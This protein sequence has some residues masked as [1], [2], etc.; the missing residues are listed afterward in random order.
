MRLTRREF[1]QL[2]GAAATALTLG[3]CFGGLAAN[4]GSAGAASASRP[5]RPNIILIV[6]DD[7]GFSDLGCYGSEISTPNIDKLAANGLRGTQF[8][9]TARCCPSRAALMTGLYPHRAGMGWMTVA[10]LGQPGYV[11]ELNEHCITIAQGLKPAGYRCYM[12]GKWHLCFDK[13]MQADSPKHNWPLQRGYD[14]YYG[15]LAGDGSHYKPLGLTRD[16]TR[17]DAP[18]EGYY[19]TDATADNAVQ[20]VNEHYVEHGED[21]F[22][23]YVAFYAPHRPL[24]AKA[25]DIAKYRG[26]YMIGWDEIR[27]R[28]YQKQKDL[29]LMDGRW[30]L[31]P[32]D[33]AVPAWDN[34]PQSAR[35][36]WDMRMATYAAMI[37]CLDQGVGRILQA[38]EKNRALDNTVIVFISDNGACA[39]TAGTG[40]ISIIGTP[41]TTESYRTNWANASDTPYRL[42]KSYVHEGGIS[43]PLIVH[44]PAG[45]TVAKG[46]FCPTVGHVIDL[47]PTFLE[48]GGAR[49]PTELAGKELYPLSGKSLA[50]IFAGK[51]VPREALY[52]EHEVNRAVRRGKMKLVSRAAM[53][54]P[55][56]GPWELYDLE[57]DRTETN[58]LA[59]Q[60]ADMVNEMAEMWDAWAKANNVYPLDG[61][62][63]NVKIRASVR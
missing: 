5:K 55:Y 29:G 15:G 22:F 10:D 57:K 1:L 8:Y 23:M 2:N 58:D 59:A 27:K 51:D 60:N 28:R 4:P 7:M 36:L 38:L 61:R 43:A 6:A 53:R 33:S 44:W 39:E 34:V 9:N 3:G 17:I 42:Y 12:T 35:P 13:H 37:D 48:L 14:R 50:P 56:T 31:S 21:P 47:M 19:Y 62:G 20:F 45:L 49:Y 25:P 18:D 41:A 46:S 11:G 24:H 32:R 52:Y 16:N 54:P 30:E 63:W 26:Q 40:D